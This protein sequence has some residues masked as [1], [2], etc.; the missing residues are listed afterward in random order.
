MAVSPALPSVCSSPGGLEEGPE[1]FRGPCRPRAA[2]FPRPAAGV[3]T[4]ALA[5]G[6]VAALVPPNDQSSAAARGGPGCKWLR[7]LNKK[8][9]IKGGKNPRES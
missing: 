3:G 9:K 2:R 1:M 8:S 5:V 6:V 7:S 4:R